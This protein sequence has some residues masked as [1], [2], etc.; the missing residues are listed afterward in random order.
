VN[1]QSVRNWEVLES[2]GG[3]GGLRGLALFGVFC[4]VFGMLALVTGVSARA[5]AGL[6]KQDQSGAGVMVS[7]QATAK[8]VG[9]PV[10]PGAKAHK[11]EKEDSPSVQLGLWGSSFGFK[12]AVMKMESNDAPDKYCGILQKSPGEIWDGFELLGPIADGERQGQG[13]IVEQARVR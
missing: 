6:G 2:R 11:D 13:G 8:D 10:Y 9:L 1:K 4:G 12:L 3:A 7:K 5:S